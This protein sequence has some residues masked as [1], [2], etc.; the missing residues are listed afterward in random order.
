MKALKA[1]LVAG[2]ASALISTAAFA[3]DFED[4]TAPASGEPSAWDIAFG[5]TLTSDYIGRG[6]SWT[7]GGAAIQPWAELTVG[8]FYAGYWGSNVTGD[9]EHD[10]SVGIRP[11]LGPFTFDI[12]YVQYLYSLA[13]DGGSE[14]YGKVEVTPV[15]PVTIGAG[16]WYGLGIL[17]TTSY[18]EVN[19][20]IDLIEDLSASAAVGWVNDPNALVMGSYTTW[21]AGLTWTPVDPFELDLRYYSSPFVSKVVVSASISSS[22]RSIGWLH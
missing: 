19:A 8:W 4:A 21:N 6:V 7:D 20:S 10:L 22:L 3:A 16:Y 14:V 11:E 2:A 9:W 5:V 13:G 18:A 12:G 1:V 17:D 15:D